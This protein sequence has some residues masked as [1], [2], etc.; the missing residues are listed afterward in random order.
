MR[1]P[2]LR[3]TVLLGF[4][5]LW[6]IPMS[7]ISGDMERYF[8]TAPAAHREIRLAVF[9]P[10]VATIKT[11][12]ALQDLGFL[13]VPGLIVIGVYHLKE[14]TDYAESRRYVRGNGLDWFRFHEV[15]A[16]ISEDSLFRENACTAEYEK[17]FKGSDGI[18]FFGGPDIPP[19][20]YGEKANFLTIV[21]DPFRHYFEVS[22]VFHLLGGSQ[23]PAF[24]GLLESRPL[25]P[26]L[27][28][29]LGCQTLNAG[30]GGTLIQDIWQE[31]Y[32][33]EAVEDALALGS[34]HWHTNPHARLHPG[35]NLITCSFHRIVLDEKG[36]LGA[37]MGFSSADR[38]RVL[39]SHHQALET[40]GRGLK[41]IATSE[42]GKIIEAVAHE[43]YGRVLGVQ[44]HPE[45]RMLWEGEPRFHQTPGDSSFSY[46]GLLED[47]PPSWAFHKAI[48]G[49][50]GAALKS[51]RTAGG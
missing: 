30:T 9:N 32:G 8:D 3:R 7:L 4:L 47:A 6:T 45:N 14:A 42:D 31:V 27:G 21:D 15:S 12:A 44:F 22:A 35:E 18:I 46:K 5:I 50:L 38:P 51:G 23:D 40:L 48:W 36:L 34:P 33:A 37:S 1:H 26:V 20:V 39:S 25:F 28:I 43:K 41:T 16:A 24:R 17:I 10:S 19:G 2:F 49:W 13:D 11:V 29:C